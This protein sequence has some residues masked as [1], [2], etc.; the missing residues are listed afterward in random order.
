MW[1]KHGVT[2]KR[3]PRTRPPLTQD[4]LRELA[5]RYVG[6]FATSRARLAAYLDRKLRER[7][8][9]EAADPDAQG[10]ADRL[11][12]LGYVD[13]RAFAEA[14]ARSLSRR[15]LGARRI[16]EDL[17]HA[18][19]DGDDG[20]AGMAVADAQ[21]VASAVRLAR[22]RKLGP[23]GA[24]VDRA[25][26]EKAIASLLRG[27]HDLELARLIVDWPAPSGGF[28]EETLSKLILSRL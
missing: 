5:L 17:R 27:G 28:T 2:A 9:D 11:A 21:R 26:R 12:E 13:D 23:F 18:G 8:W 14:R 3:S 7:G 22:R 24:P 15:G 20:V 1:H 6:R 10:L 19:I 4:S 25:G 16:R